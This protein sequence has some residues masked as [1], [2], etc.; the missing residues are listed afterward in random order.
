M[1]VEVQYHD[2]EGSVCPFCGQ[3]LTVTAGGAFPMIDEED[4]NELKFDYKDSR[5]FT[6]DGY[7]VRLYPCVCPY[8]HLTFLAQQN[9]E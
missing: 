2:E 7:E 6:H 8:G 9:Q 4:D 1:L 3:G 5:R